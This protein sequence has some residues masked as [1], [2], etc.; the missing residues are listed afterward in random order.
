TWVFTGHSL[1]CRDQQSVRGGTFHSYLT[2]TLRDRLGRDQDA[3]I[4]TLS[5]RLTLRDVLHDY[6]GRI[7]RFHPE[8]VVLSCGPAELADNGDTLLDFE[9]IFHELIF[10]IERQGALTVVNTPP[11]R[12]LTDEQG[13]MDQLV[14]LEA[15]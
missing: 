15:I 10:R 11:Y 1:T 7:G 5:P 12:K 14:R 13:T 2:G 3:F 4:S 8:V 9:E 6:N